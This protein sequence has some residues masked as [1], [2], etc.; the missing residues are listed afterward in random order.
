V[1]ARAVRSGKTQARKA[2]KQKVSMNDAKP[3]AEDP[4]TSAPLAQQSLPDAGLTEDAALSLLKNRDLPAETLEQI[5]KDPVTATSRKLRFAI[6]SHLHSPR[7]I[8]MRLVREFHTSDLMRFALLPA[9][10]ADLKHVANELLVSRLTSVTLG[11]RISLARRAAEGVVVALLL[12]KEPRVWQAALQNPRLTE[13]AIVK[14]LLRASASAAFV[15]AVCHDRKWSVRREIR[16]ALL[17]NEKTPLARA[18]E[19]ARML[20]PAQLRDILHNSRLPEK[21]KDYLR[22]DLQMRNQKVRS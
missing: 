17:R 9:V 11:E 18:I 16:M 22:K 5:S 14:A 3:D 19:F 20:P 7:H 4:M 8:T 10:A 13:A 21:M 12:D 1:T 15:E 6:A 2:A